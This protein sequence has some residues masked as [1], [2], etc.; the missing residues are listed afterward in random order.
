VD[1]LE[2]SLS[3]V[4]SGEAPNVPIVEVRE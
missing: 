4:R 1:R 3:G 2:V